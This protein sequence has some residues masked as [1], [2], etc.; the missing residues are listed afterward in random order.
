VDNQDDGAVAF[1]DRADIGTVCR[2]GRDRRRRRHACRDL[3]GALMSH[4]WVC[5]QRSRSRLP[6]PEQCSQTQLI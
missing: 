5:K 1:I 2:D 4:A 6:V 3:R